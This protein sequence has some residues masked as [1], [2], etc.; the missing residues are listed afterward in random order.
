MMPETSNEMGDN[1]NEVSMGWISEYSRLPL[2]RAKENYNLDAS[3][4]FT[5]GSMRRV[6]NMMM[7]EIADELGWKRALQTW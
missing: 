1:L 6:L 2:I 5:E 7:F 4:N 3:A